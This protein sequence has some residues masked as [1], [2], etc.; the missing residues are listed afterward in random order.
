[1]CFNSLYT[2]KNSIQY[3][4]I[5]TYRAVGTLSELIKL[6]SLRALTLIGKTNSLEPFYSILI[7]TFHN[8]LLHLYAERYA[9]IPLCG[10]IL[11]S[12]VGK[13]SVTT[14]SITIFQETIKK[15]YELVERDI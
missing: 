10:V 4:N 12:I 15:I 11:I 2:I 13:N 9:L 1:M 8:K 14:S 5:K 7:V 3:R 6:A